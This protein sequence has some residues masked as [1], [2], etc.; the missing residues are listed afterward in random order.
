MVHGVNNPLNGY[1][2]VFVSVNLSIMDGWGWMGSK[3]NTLRLHVEG[4]LLHD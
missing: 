4:K 2:F 1:E 3:N